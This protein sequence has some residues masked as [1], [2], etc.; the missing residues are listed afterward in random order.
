MFRSRGGANGWRRSI[1]EFDA[2]HLPDSSTQRQPNSA[3]ET[4]D[5]VA[6]PQK[7]ADD[8]LLGRCQFGFFKRDHFDG[9][10]CAYRRLVDVRSRILNVSMNLKNTETEFGFRIVL[11]PRKYSLDRLLSRART[12]QTRVVSCQRDPG[13]IL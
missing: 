13:A 9:F 11:R 6:L 1:C 3:G 4:D 5:A 7:A 10:G 12:I 8:V 2:V